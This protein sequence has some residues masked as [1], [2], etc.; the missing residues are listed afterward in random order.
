M[1]IDYPLLHALREALSPMFTSMALRRPWRFTLF[2]APAAIEIAGEYV[3]AGYFR[4]LGLRPLLG[5]TSHSRRTC[6]RTARRL[7]C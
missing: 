2:A 4:V 6:R 7:R 3:N 1:G 5:R